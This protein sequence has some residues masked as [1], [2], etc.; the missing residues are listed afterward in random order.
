[1][2]R[3]QSPLMSMTAQKQLGKELIY[4]MKGNRAF[5]TGYSRPGRK[6]PFTP[7]DDQTEKRDFYASAVAV[8]QEKNDAQKAYWNDLAKAK[9]LNMSGW[10]L[11]YQNLFNEQ[12][13]GLKN[14]YYGTRYY[15]SFLYGQQE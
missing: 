5:V 2:V 12:S 13:W 6:N 14:S 7:S 9:N 10:N 1:M 3:V 8:W 4:K 15:S 11:F